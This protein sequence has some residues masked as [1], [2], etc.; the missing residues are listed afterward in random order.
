LIDALQR[1]V[2][3]L[4]SETLLL[5][6][7]QLRQRL[8]ALDVL[9]AYFPNYLQS[10][11]KDGSQ[12]AGL[13][14]RA[15]AIYDRLNAVNCGLYETIRTEIQFGQGPDALLQWV[16]PSAESEHLPAPANGMGYDYLDE[17]INGVCQF[18]E[19]D[20]G[21]VQRDSEMVFYQPTPARHI[22]SL[23]RQTA[24]IATD[25][26][27]D[28][29]SGLGHVPLLVS[30]CTTARSIGIELETTYVKRARQCARR[31]KLSKVAFIEHDAQAAD[32]SLGTVFYLHTPFTG[33]ILRR[34]LNRLRR[35]AATRPI[36]IC[37][38]GPC[39]AV[40]ADEPW[41][42]ITAAPVANRI[43]LFYSRL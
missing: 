7:T 12:V 35:E 16:R 5:E 21:P 14:L 9:D 4:E 2:G 27:V 19:P 1:L 26:F 40:I 31:L 37:T 29:G 42:E 18:E 13:Y 43:A 24:L 30:I 25:V 36:R 20:R 22:F 34:V 17:L 38:F 41:L 8:E 6:P 3:R 15:K 28:L 11:G 32:L 39:T 33:S 10:V 23:I